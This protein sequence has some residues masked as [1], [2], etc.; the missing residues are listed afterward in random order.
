MTKKKTKF[1]LLLIVAVI[2]LVVSL[3]LSI[4]HINYVISFEEW[5]S[6]MTRENAII[7]SIVC[8][9]ASLVSL[10]L[11]IYFIIKIFKINKSKRDFLQGD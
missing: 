11:I 8:L 5:F 1:I 2:L 4:S 6:Y 3:I 7:V 10:C 9:L